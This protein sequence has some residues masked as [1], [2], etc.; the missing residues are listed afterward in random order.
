MEDNIKSNFM[1]MGLEH[2]DLINLAW[3]EDRWEAFV[4]TVRILSFHKSFEYFL[5]TLAYC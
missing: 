4:S 5:T 1:V 2:V 3:V